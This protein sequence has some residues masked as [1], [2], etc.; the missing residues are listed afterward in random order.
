MNAKN[1]FKSILLVGALFFTTII[2]A[3]DCADFT[4]F[5][6]GEEEGKK[7]HVLYRDLIENEKY[8]DAFPMWEQL[9]KYAPAGHVY[10]FID[11]VT[12]YNAL[13]DSATEAKKKEKVAE[14]TQKIVNLFEHRLACMSPERGDSNIVFEA[15]AYEMSAHGYED[16]DKTLAMFEQAT[17]LGG[18]KTSA[19]IL[20]YYADHVAFMFGND[21]LSKDKA[22]EAYMTL[23]AIKNANTA[24]TDYAEN[25]VYVE[26]Y[27]RPYVGYIFDCGYFLDKLRPKYDAAPDNPYNFRPI[28][29][30]LLE[31]NCD[32]NAPFV[33]E[34]MVKDSLF[35]IVYQDSVRKEHEQTNPDFVAKGLMSNGNYVQAVPLLERA[36]AMDLPVNRKADANYYL[37]RIYHNKGGS[38]NFSK[39]RRYYEA[40]ASLKPNWGEPLYQIGVLYASSGPLCGPGTGWESQKVVWPAMDMWNKAINT[41]D[42]EIVEKAKEK[43]NY[44]SQYLP[45]KEDAHLRGISN[46]SNITIGCWIQ[47]TTKVRLRSQY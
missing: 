14:Y 6:G 11:G 44:Y 32:F 43:I 38:G 18:N 26:E 21:L 19:Y 17:A 25:W 8:D 39:A 22:R 16:I 40:A 45:T 33:R 27:Y 5:P 1:I 15:M 31:K 37:A 36:V 9:M 42:A 41:G 4:N 24:D 34:L 46:E 2:F 23:E 30:T 7:V 12:M 13:I 3:Q 20:A 28:L 10:H 29:R 35:N 47:R